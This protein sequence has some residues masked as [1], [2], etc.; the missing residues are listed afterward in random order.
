MYSVLKKVLE[1]RYPLYRS[2]GIRFK[3]V[4]LENIQPVH[5]GFCL[6]LFTTKSFCC[7]FSQ[8]NRDHQQK[9]HTAAFSDIRRVWGVG[10][11][12]R[13]RVLL[14]FSAQLTGESYYSTSWYLYSV[15]KKVPE[16]RYPL[17]HSTGIRFKK[18]FLSIVFTI[19]KKSYFWNIQPVQNKNCFCGPSPPAPDGAA[20]LPTFRSAITDKKKYGQP[21]EIFIWFVLT[22]NFICGGTRNKSLKST[23]DLEVN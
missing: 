10:C 13:R 15:I 21:S 20:D 11:G 3:K 4:V 18:L 23:S 14:R 16:Y 22:N 7:A 9:K 5:L 1:Y 8:R 6:R 12:V 19:L 17:Y 2:T